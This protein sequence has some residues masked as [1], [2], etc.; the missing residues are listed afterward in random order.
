MVACFLSNQRARTNCSHIVLM[1]PF[2]GRGFLGGTG[3]LLR[4]CV[5]C[6]VSSSSW[7][8]MTSRWQSL[9]QGQRVPEGGQPLSHWIECANQI[10]QLCRIYPWTAG[11]GSSAP[12]MSCSAAGTVTQCV[13]RYPLWS[14]FSEPEGNFPCLRLLLATTSIF[15]HCD[16][17]RLIFWILNP[18]R[19]YYFYSRLFDA[20]KAHMQNAFSG[21]LPAQ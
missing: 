9:K 20:A 7:G 5:L 4:C 15:A 6:D 1:W 8:G 12:H 2:L 11:A 14:S 21:Y 3:H 10:S 16:L 13:L 17:H 19:D 18:E